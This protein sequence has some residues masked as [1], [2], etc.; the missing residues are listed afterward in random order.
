MAIKFASNLSRNRYGVL[1]FRLA[2]PPDLRTHFK[3][4]EIYRSLRTASINEATSVAQTLSIAFKRV[5]KEIRQQSMSDNKKTPKTSLNVEDGIPTFID[6]IEAERAR[7]GAQLLSN[8]DDSIQHEG[9]KADQMQRLTAMLAYHER[10][11]QLEKTGVDDSTRAAIKAEYYRLD[12][13]LDSLMPQVIAIK[14]RDAEL[15]T[16]ASQLLNDVQT[17]A[18]SRKHREVI[19][20]QNESHRLEKDHLA[21]FVA[22]IASK[23]STP[24]PVGSTKPISK[25]IASYVESEAAEQKQEPRTLEAYQAAINTFIKIVGDK[26]LH[27]LGFEDRNRFEDVIKKLPANSTKL[28]ASRDLGVDEML[29]LGLKPISLNSAKNI[30]RRTN[31]FLLWACRRENIALPFELLDK[32]KIKKNA[33]GKQRRRAFKDDELRIVFNP[34]TLAA[35][36]Q[37]APYMHWLPLISAH[38]GM[39]INEIAQLGISDIVTLNG[40][41]CFNVTDEPDPVEER[42]LIREKSVKTEAGKRLVPVHRRL[43]ELGLLNYVTMLRSAG[44]TRLFPDLIGGRDGPG[45]PA[46]KHFGR[47][48]DKIKLSDPTLCFHSFR[49]GAV[50]KMR[51]AKVLRELRMVV[52][53]HSTLEDTHDWYGD[54]QND[55]SIEDKAEAINAINFDGVI[56]YVRL[57]AKAPTL[58]DLNRALDRRARRE[59]KPIIKP[60]ST[61]K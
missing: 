42:E 54:I 14:D 47:Y 56:D 27:C 32:V 36:N 1:H 11:T 38:S 37:G 16:N 52:I 15:E 12:A 18:L 41:Q 3:T 58:A 60:A 59:K 4:K 21:N 8:L 22:S 61:T 40:I 25:Y 7:L 28:A 49:H 6:D 34:A 53:G 9:K 48:C 33:K 23:I 29:E 24:A 51:A 30:A 5:F 19:N 2:V 45:Q 39:R 26:P 17:M 50:S 57:E 20:E 35:S 10:L 43:I 13:I 44:H 55:Y 46:S 31:A